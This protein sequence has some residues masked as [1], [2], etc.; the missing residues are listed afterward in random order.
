MPFFWQKHFNIT[1][2]L[3]FAILFMKAFTSIPLSNRVRCWL[4]REGPDDVR[5]DQATQLFFKSVRQNH[6]YAWHQIVSAT[7]SILDHKLCGTIK[8]HVIQFYPSI[9]KLVFILFR[10][11]K[12][13][14]L[15]ILVLN[16]AVKKYWTFFVIHVNR[17]RLC[18]FQ[19][20]ISVVRLNLEI[21]HF[22]LNIEI[23]RQGTGKKFAYSW[24]GESNYTINTRNFQRPA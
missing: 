1:E 16:Y 6:Y 22:P 9:I 10:L 4:Q 18:F 7:S 2:E 20:R 24:L 19:F 23:S 12:F 3:G 15:N 5:A 13:S 11:W 21:D 17:D 14:T 8:S